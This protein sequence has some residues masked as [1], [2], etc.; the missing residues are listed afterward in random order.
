MTNEPG[1]RVGTDAGLPAIR[2]PVVVEGGLRDLLVK[3]DAFWGRQLCGLVFAMNHGEGVGDAGKKSANG[4]AVAAYVDAG[5]ATFGEVFAEPVGFVKGRGEQRGGDLEAHVT[6]VVDGS[7]AVVSDLV[8]V[9]G[10]LR[11]DVLVFALR[12][13]DGGPI[14]GFEFGKFDRYG[15]VGCVLVSDC[16]ADVVG[17]GR[18]MAKASSLALCALRKRATTKSP[19]RT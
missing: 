6:E 1:E 16:V 4:E 11:L 17:K 15:Q 8:D 2:G 13:G 7:H 3:L 14:L 12:I 10:E 19:V 5:R 18:P 9:E